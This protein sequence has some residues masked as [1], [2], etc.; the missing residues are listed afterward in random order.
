MCTG[1]RL[2]WKQLVYNT[3]MLSTPQLAT[4]S[5]YVPIRLPPTPLFGR[6]IHPMAPPPLYPKPSHHKH[7]L[8][9]CTKTRFPKVGLF[10][11]RNWFSLPT[12]RGGNDSTPSWRTGTHHKNHRTVAVRCLSYILARPDRHLHSRCRSSHGKSALV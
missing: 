2:Q 3:A 12:I 9:R 7:P 1:N 6:I 11:T 10:S 5:I 4:L 8:Y